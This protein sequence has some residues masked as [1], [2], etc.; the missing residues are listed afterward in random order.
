VLGWALR[1]LGVRRVVASCLH[2][3][4]ASQRGLEKLGF[5]RVG[6]EGALLVWEQDT[7]PG[8]SRV[9]SSRGMPVRPV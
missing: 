6:R 5:Q 7:V 3:N 4:I 9:R 8:V 1:Q 2:D